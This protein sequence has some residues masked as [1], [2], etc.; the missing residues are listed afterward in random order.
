MSLFIE[1]MEDCQIMDKSSI[2]DGE[3]GFETEYKP[4]ALIKAAITY[5]NTLNAKTAQ[6]QGVKSVYMVTTPLSVN[7][8]YHDV[9]K[10]LE[11]GKIFRI[12]SDGNDRRTP[13]T[14]SF[15]FRRVSAEEW[16]L[17]T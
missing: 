1:Q 13:K 5:N 15:E 2:S 11:D 3:S 12:T 9:I 14:A 10:R 17:P 16:E 6:A 4:G 8:Q 7:L